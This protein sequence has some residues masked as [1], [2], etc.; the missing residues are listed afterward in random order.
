MFKEGTNYLVP[1]KTYS[2]NGVP[3]TGKSSS[4]SNTRPSGG[5]GC[6]SFVPCRTWP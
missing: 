2:E 5:G 4:S 1:I 3:Y 6:H